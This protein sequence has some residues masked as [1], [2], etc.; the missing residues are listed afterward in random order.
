MQT[1]TG[2]KTRSLWDTRASTLH[3]RANKGEGRGR[4][5]SLLAS[6]HAVIFHIPF[7]WHHGCASS[8]VSTTHI[9]W[10]TTPALVPQASSVLAF[11]H[12]R[13]PPHSQELRAEMFHLTQGNA[14]AYSLTLSSHMLHQYH[15]LVLYFYLSPH[16]CHCL[17]FQHPSWLCLSHLYMPMYSCCIRVP[18]AACN[19][20]FLSFPPACWHQSLFKACKSPCARQEDG[21]LIHPHYQQSA[22]R[23]EQPCQLLRNETIASIWWISWLS[24]LLIRQMNW[25]KKHSLLWTNDSL[26]SLLFKTWLASFSYFYF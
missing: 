1:K 3:P 6:A 8:H 4:R 19:L 17:E 15:A 5:I 20:C 21:F 10:Y 13:I 26:T 9:T 12:A 16:L 11:R 7:P 18:D 2:V 14:C 24:T 25:K 22:S 23:S